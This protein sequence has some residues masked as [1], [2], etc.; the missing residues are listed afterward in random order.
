MEVYAV[1]ACVFIIA[2]I[3]AFIISLEEEDSMF[4]LMASIFFS[5][6]AACV[7]LCFEL[8]Y[9]KIKQSINEA[10]NIYINGDPVSDSFNLDGITLDRY[11]IRIDGDNVYLETK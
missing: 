7:I 3:I 4:F 9:E 10:E 2:G 5:M 11:H 6:G 1:G 8:K